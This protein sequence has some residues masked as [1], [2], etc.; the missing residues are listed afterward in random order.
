MVRKKG[1]CGFNKTVSEKD[2]DLCTEDSHGGPSGLCI[3]HAPCDEKDAIAFRDAIII[4]IIKAEDEAIKTNRPIE[5]NVLLDCR[6]FVFPDIDIC[7]YGRKFGTPADFSRAKFQEAAL[8]S[9]AKFEY[10]VKFDDTEFKAEALF[11]STEF[12]GDA[13]FRKAKFGELTEF[14]FSAFELKGDFF[15]AQFEGET[16]FAGT[17]FG[18]SAGFENAVFS[19]KANFWGISKST[20]FEIKGTREEVP[21]EV[22]FRFVTFEKPGDLHFMDL[23]LSE[24]VFAGTNAIQ[25]ADYV[26]VKWTGKRNRK[27][28]GD[29]LRA[30]MGEI[31]HEVVA[32]VYRRLRQNYESRL[33]YG[34]AGDFFVG[35][36]IMYRKYLFKHRRL[37]RWGFSWLYNLFS[38]YRESIWLPL[39]WLLTLFV[40]TSYFYSF[41]GQ[42]VSEALRSSFLGF[43]SLKIDLTKGYAGWLIPSLQRIIVIPLITLF[44]LALRRA[45]RR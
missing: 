3:F 16:W 29:E 9:Y 40:A 22:D 44:I 5:N 19:K 38:R 13:S 30:R 32:E 43:V 45:F 6:G 28:V 26:D 7:F 31:S 8:F 14:W 36:M 41:S 23:D 24:W 33:S 34:E 4:Y 42:S 2:P 27:T 37:L 10:E 39:A 17:K 11:N 21:A 20:S 1:E 35:Q 12:S 25:Y 15:M 18:D